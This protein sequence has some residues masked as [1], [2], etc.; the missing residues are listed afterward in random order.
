MV[1]HIAVMAQ[2]VKALGRGFYSHMQWPVMCG[3][4]SQHGRVR[5][6]WDSPPLPREVPSP[7]S[8]P[9]IGTRCVKTPSSKVTGE[10]VGDG[11]SRRGGGNFFLTYLQKV[12]FEHDA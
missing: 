6:W 9:V 2:C 8:S 12:N 11:T 4:D 3:F 7:T 5:W 10:G 1:I